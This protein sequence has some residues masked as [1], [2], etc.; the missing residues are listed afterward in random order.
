M[1]RFDASKI[2]NCDRSLIVYDK[3]GNE[4]SVLKM[5]E[6]RIYISIDSIPKA[7]RNAFIAAEDVR[8]TSTRAL[9]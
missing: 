9:I 7:V 4:V 1:A 6:N 3:D 8:F 5:S 2:L